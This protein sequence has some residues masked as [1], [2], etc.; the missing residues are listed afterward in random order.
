MNLKELA[1]RIHNQN[2]EAGWWDDYLDDKESRHET[3]MMLVI[4]ELSE[5]M[6]G[7]RKNIMDD[8]LPEYKM[9]DVELADALIR[10]L[11]L[12]GA[13]ADEYID[14]EDIIGGP[15]LIMLGGKSVPEQ[16][17]YIIRDMLQYYKT[18]YDRQVYNGIVSIICMA[19]IHGV[20]LETIVEKKLAYNKKRADHKRENREAEDGKRY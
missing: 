18:D 13:Y 9:F 7:D 19:S 16:L 11:D 3:A 1:D 5:A 15:K 20:D 10:L 6:E 8:H 2:L 17:M 12:A 4:S 14:R